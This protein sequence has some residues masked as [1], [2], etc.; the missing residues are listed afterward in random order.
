LTRTDHPRGSLGVALADWL[1]HPDAN[2]LR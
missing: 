1:D 2:A